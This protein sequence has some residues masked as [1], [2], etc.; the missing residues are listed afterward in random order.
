[1]WDFY[2]FLCN[3]K[4][5]SRACSQVTPRGQILDYRRLWPAGH[6]IK[7]L[8]IVPLNHR[9]RYV[10]PSWPDCLLLKLSSSSCNDQES[11]MLQ[12]LAVVILSLGFLAQWTLNVSSPVILLKLQVSKGDILSVYEGGEVHDLYKVQQHAWLLCCFM[13]KNII[14]I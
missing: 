1:M 9:D 2:E 14:P 11:D 13:Y 12:A 5:F 10:S 8:V 7:G 3:W 4:T 6:C